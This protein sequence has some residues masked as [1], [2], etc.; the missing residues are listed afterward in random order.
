VKK[1][2]VIGAGPAGLTAAY[3]LVKAGH[4][5]TVYEASEYVGGMARSFDLWGQRV[6]C[7]PHRFFSKD[8]VVNDLFKEV[9]G[10][11]FVRVNRMTRIYYKNR[12]FNYPLKAMNVVLNLGILRVIAVMWSYL[13]MRMNPIND[14]K[15]FEDWVSNRFGKR[16]FNMFF[17]NYSEKLWGIPCAHID[18]DWAAQRIKKFSLMEAVRTALFGD[19]KNKHKTLVDQFKYPKQGT[20][21]IYTKMQAKILAMGGKIELN[22]PVQKVIQDDAGNAVGV[23]TASGEDQADAIVSTMPLTTMIK[24]LKEVP[25]AVVEAADHLFY[26]NTIL[27]YLEVEQTDIFPDNWLYV[28]APEVRHG[29]VTNFRNWSPQLYGEA[30]TSILCMEFWCFESEPM[31]DARDDELSQL[32]QEEIRRIKLISDH[33]KIRNT[34]V[35]RIPKCYPVYRTGY[36]EHLDVLQSFVDGIDNLYPIGR[37]GAF[38]YNNQDHSMLMGILAARELDTG[39]QQSLWSINTDSEYQE[40]GHAMDP[41]D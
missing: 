31:W 26:R 1:F 21:S 7:G 17:R 28:H 11:D 20:G 27:V 41:E 30:D 38:K 4:E 18:A 15:T 23:A 35:L 33:I 37:Y 39:K 2:I 22:T 3:E 6:D 12:F 32:A 36:Q 13:R 16:L 34:H 8:R 40:E 25:T 10:D 24:G 29:R 19:P 14:P 5:V 9:V